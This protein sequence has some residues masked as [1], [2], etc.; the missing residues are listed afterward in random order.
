MLETVLQFTVTAQEAEKTL[1]EV[2]TTQ[3]GVS[4][5]LLTRAKHQG[6]ILVNGEVAFVSALLKPGDQ[7]EVMIEQEQTEHLQAEPMPLAIRYEDQDMLVL[8]KPAGIVVHPT[9][10][11]HQ[12]TLANG[13]IAYWQAKGE[14]RRFRPVNRLDKDTSGLMIVAK[15]QWAHEQFSR[16]QQERTLK[17]YYQ[18]IVEGVMEQPEG[19]IEA[20]IGRAD[21]SIIE[22]E[23]RE[24]GQYAR[25]HFTVLA[26]GPQAALVELSLETGRTHQIRVHLSYMGHPLLGDDLYGGSLA[27]INRQ[28]LHAVRL[29][30]LHPR[31]QER[32]DFYEP[33]PEDME[34]LLKQVIGKQ[35]H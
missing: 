13:V 9:G 7:V 14:H 3:F 11:H 21:H 25:T 6:R 15:N 29:S 34:Q 20:P 19:V 28:A 12:G 26:Q 35:Q 10:N 33:L 4:R 32:L 23:V 5:R 22:R 17:R 24:D 2:L 1:R 18:A 30:F 16:M 31:S 27:L 8:A